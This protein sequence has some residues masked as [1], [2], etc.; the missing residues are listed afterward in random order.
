MLNEASIKV[1]EVPTVVVTE[2]RLQ[3]AVA[4]SLGSP[5]ASLPPSAKKHILQS[6]IN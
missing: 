1:K 4:K 2:I 5:S 6:R 3:M